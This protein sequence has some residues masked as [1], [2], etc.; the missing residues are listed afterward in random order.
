MASQGVCVLVV[1]LLFASQALAGE[2]VSLLGFEGAKPL[3]WR[4]ASLLKKA[5]HKVLGFRAPRDPEDTSALSAFAEKRRVDIFVAGAAEENGDGWELKLTLL[6]AD[7]ERRGTPLTFEGRTI[8]AIVKELKADSDRLDRAVS[9]G[10]SSEAQAEQPAAPA[11]RGEV[12]LD[13]PTES[14]APPAPVEV[15]DPDPAKDAEPP[16]KKKAAAKKSG[17]PVPFAFMQS[18]VS[19]EE[20]TDPEPSAAPA[21]PAPIDADEAAPDAEAE[22]S[23]ARTK[24]F[25]KRLS[26]KPKEQA[27]DSESGG[28]GGEQKPDSELQPEPPS[29]AEAAS[30]GSEAVGVDT[31]VANDSD[32]AS[33][34]AW[35]TVVLNINA[36]LV[37]R[38]LSYVDDLYG[39]LRAPT[40]NSWVYNVSA[41]VYPFAKPVKDRIALVAGYESA[42]SGKVRDDNLDSEFSVNFSELYGG[43]RFRQPIGNHEFGV[44]ATIGT[45]TAGLDDP[46]QQSR[47]PEFDYTLLRGSADVGLNFGP[48]SVRAG[49]GY[50]LPLGGFGQASTVDWFPRMEGSGIEGFGGLHYRFSDDVGFDGSAMVRRYVLSMNSTPEDAQVGV[51]EVAGGAVDLYVSWYFGLTLTL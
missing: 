46:D 32:S 4:V 17:R 7:G 48:V 10:G 26:L 22:A 33:K 29:D 6:G 45:M 42:F 23:A 39:R 19:A 47:I 14:E 43:A 31:A 8:R 18:S 11:R 37:Y 41:A 50:R 38:T 28:W 9:A 44:Q 51:S 30:A 16:P 24:R 27:S 13:A 40:T 3:R 34:S 49:A 36:G 21:D 25:R 12:D 35:P 1:A 5:G 20:P 15:D 2:R